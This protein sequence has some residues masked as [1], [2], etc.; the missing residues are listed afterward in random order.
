MRGTFFVRMKTDLIKHRPLRALYFCIPNQLLKASF[1]RFLKCKK[2][3]I[4]DWLFLVDRNIE[5]SNLIWE[6]LEE[7]S[8]INLFLLIP[9]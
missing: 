3:V 1:Q 7:V 2:P 4:N 9:F 8:R 5:L 6:G